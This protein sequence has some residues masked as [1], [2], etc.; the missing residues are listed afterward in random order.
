[1]YVLICITILIPLLN[2]QYIY[3]YI[4]IYIYYIDLTIKCKRACKDIVDA[5]VSIDIT[6]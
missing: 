5:Y 3:I 2:M 4:Y 1:M 6:K